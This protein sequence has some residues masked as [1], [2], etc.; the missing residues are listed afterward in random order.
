MITYDHPRTFC[1]CVLDLFATLFPGEKI[2]ERTS[3]DG[4]VLSW[5][6]VTV[7]RGSSTL[8]N[9]SRAKAEAFVEF[10]VKVAARCKMS[11][12]LNP[13]WQEKMP[14][15]MYGG[16]FTQFTG[17]ATRRYSTHMPTPD[18]IFEGM[19]HEDLFAHLFGRKP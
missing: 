15:N 9:P 14:K 19:S 6:E 5:R 17:R 10:C 2:R 12:A 13:K 11:F 16:H 18:D 7:Q 4:L 8:E 1:W 3:Q